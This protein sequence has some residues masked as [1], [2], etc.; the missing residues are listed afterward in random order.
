V[1]S[2]NKQKRLLWDSWCYKERVWRWT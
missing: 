2:N 1:Q